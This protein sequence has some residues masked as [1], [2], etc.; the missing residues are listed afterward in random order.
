MGTIGNNNGGGQRLHDGQKNYQHSNER[1]RD[2]ARSNPQKHQY[3]NKEELT[4]DENYQEG[5]PETDLDFRD[6]SD[7]LEDQ[8][9]S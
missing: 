6:K 7:N 9:N 8:N 4:N 1:N 5:K 3:E 2:H